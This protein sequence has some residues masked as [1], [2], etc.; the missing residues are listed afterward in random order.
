MAITVVRTYQFTGSGSNSI[1]LSGG[2]TCVLVLVAT[3]TFSAATLG[4][5]NLTL[6]LSN[7]CAF[8]AATASGT[9]A[10]TLGSSQPYFVICYSGANTLY[11]AYWENEYTNSHTWG[12]YTLTPTIVDGRMACI[13]FFADTY[14]TNQAGWT[15]QYYYSSGDGRITWEM[16][17]RNDVEDNTSEDYS[18]YNGGANDRDMSHII[19]EVT[20]VISFIPQI[21][22]S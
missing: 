14:I 9:L 4:G 5:V 20:Q 17:T 11:N 19:A 6:S 1:D 8:I 15:T 12:G 16:R 18:F 3:T 2:V 21:I 7:R 13:N 22:I 10:M